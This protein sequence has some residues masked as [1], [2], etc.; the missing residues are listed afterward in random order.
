VPFGQ[1][2]SLAAAGA[3]AAASALVSAGAAG[4]AVVVV[5]EEPPQAVRAVRERAR[6][7]ANSFLIAVTPFIWLIRFG[8]V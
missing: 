1:S 2:M 5:E 3:A 7:A 4:A 6:T 8:S